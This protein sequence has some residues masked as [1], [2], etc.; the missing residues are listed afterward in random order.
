MHEPLL[1]DLQR[2][3]LLD[4]VTRVDRAFD[5]VTFNPNDNWSDHEILALDWNGKIFRLV[6]N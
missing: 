3:K 1:T 2:A 6:A 5:E 4:F